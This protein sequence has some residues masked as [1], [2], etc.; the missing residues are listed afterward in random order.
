LNVADTDAASNWEWRLSGE[1]GA[2]SGISESGDWAEVPRTPGARAKSVIKPNSWDTAP[3]H[4]MWIL[5]VRLRLGD[6]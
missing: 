6:L 2:R 3:V 4:L 1:G 5:V